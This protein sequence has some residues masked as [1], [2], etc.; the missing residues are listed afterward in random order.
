MTRAVKPT[1]IG[2]PAWSLMSQVLQKVRPGSGLIATDSTSASL[3]LRSR[4][5][6]SSANARPWVAST[7]GSRPLL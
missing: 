5:G 3:G 1:V 2:L 7:D 6:R 4:V